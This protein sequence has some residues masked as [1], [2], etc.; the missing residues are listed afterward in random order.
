MPTKGSG[1][2]MTTATAVVTATAAAVGCT[3]E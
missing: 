3:A 1:R 2:A